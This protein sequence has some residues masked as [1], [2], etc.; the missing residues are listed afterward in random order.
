MQFDLGAAMRK[1]EEFESA[2]LMDFEFIRRARATR[3]LA[4]SVGLDETETVRQIADCDEAGL[5]DRLL[6]LVQIDREALSTAYQR[7]LARA[8]AELVAER[9]DPAPHRMA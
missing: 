9:G 4:R 6:P 2:R 3:L 8:H 1:K 5:I 7:C